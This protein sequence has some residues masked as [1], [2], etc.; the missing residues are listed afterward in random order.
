MFIEVA[1]VLIVVLCLFLAVLMIKLLRL[2]RKMRKDNL[3]QVKT[4]ENRMTTFERSLYFHQRNQ[5]DLSDS[6]NDVVRRLVNV[7]STSEAMRCERK[8]ME[9]ESHE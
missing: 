1:T 7:E 3:K 5:T 4:L 9:R 6:I 8:Q 2:K